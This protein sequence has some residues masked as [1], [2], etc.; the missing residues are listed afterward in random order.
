MS[1]SDLCKP[2]EH[3]LSRRQWLGSVAAGVG[4]GGLA[5]P[6]LAE[7]MRRREK[8][9]LFIWL[10]GGISQLESWDPK[11]NTQFGGPFRA[12]PTTVPG[13]QI[14]EL[15]P[16]T[17]KVMHHL[18]VVRS[19][20][21]KD[22]SHSAGVARIQRGDPK[23][24]GVVYP[25]LGSAVVKLLGPGSSGLPPY[26]WIKPMSG[27]FIHQ[28]AGF[29]GPKY[30]ALALGDAKP[31]EN[32]LRNKSVTEQDD[33][34]R[35]ALRDAAD[36]R[37]AARRRPEWTEA[38]SYVYTMAEQMQK[39]RALFDESTY[40][41]KDRERYGT[42][43]IGRHMLA[44]RRFLEAGVRFVKVNSYGWD[45]HG[46]N[47][48]ASL[49][50]ISKFDQAFS[51]IVE[52]LATRGMLDHVLVVAMS[53]F[54]RTPRINGNVGRDHWP[55]AWSL[56]TGGTGIKRGVVVG[57]TNAQGTW[58]TGDEH[59]IGHLFHTWFAALGIDAKKTEYDNAGQPLPIAH[60][61]CT[62]IKELL[63]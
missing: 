43:E 40:D 52:D 41:P 37:Y 13:L 51:A 49:T 48:N 19:L 9:A 39:H 23:E 63:A 34:E 21:T 31:P 56:V 4:L 57:K 54:G 26:V 18:A 55:E 46:D 25:Y 16:R 24:R 50:M 42:H 20:C 53:E 33:R 45:S 15:L 35:N 61:D 62:A 11:P 58:V 2:W 6:G 3:R 36:R 14:S 38:N 1:L 60:D 27:G 47:F 59:D 29:L 30:G 32:L 7:A 12:I 8:Q 28:D 17:A 5:Q 44:A 22:N 10:D